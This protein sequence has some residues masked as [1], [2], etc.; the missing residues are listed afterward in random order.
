MKHPMF[1]SFAGDSKQ[2]AHRIKSHFRD[3]LA[4]AY[5]RTG[6]DGDN[7]PAEI[8]ME[9][10]Q[11]QVFVV[12]WSAAYV[13]D[14]PRRP[15]CR[16]ELLTAAKRIQQGNL[17]RFFIVQVDGT[18]LDAKLV[19]P[20]TGDLVDALSTLRSDSRAFMHPASERAIEQRLSLELA[21]I[22]HSDHPILPRDSLERALR[23]VLNTG[24]VHSKTPVIFVNGFHGSGRRTLIREVMSNQRHLT[25][26]PVPLDGIDGPEDLLRIIWGDVFHK[27]RHEQRQMMKH[28]TDDAHAIKGY[29]R[30]IGLQL[31]ANKAYL[32][33][34]K[35]DSTDLNEVAPRWLAECLGVIAP[36]VQPLVFCT[37][38]R[39]LPEFMR[40]LLPNGGDVDVPTLEERESAELAEML[41][42]AVD[43]TKVARWRP[44]MATIVEASANNPKL[45]VD[46]VRAASRRRSLDFLHR[47]IS[48]E[49]Q[50][51]DQRVQQAIEWAWETVKGEPFTVQVLDVIG[52]LGTTHIDSLKEIFV[53]DS[54]RIGDAIYHLVQAGLV[55]HLSESTYR[56]PKA[57]ARKL[58]LYV[59]GALPRSQSM[60]LLRKFARRILSEDEGYSALAMNNRLQLQLSM[61]AVIPE[62]DLVFITAAMLFKAGWQ[63]YRLGQFGAALPMLRRA[64]DRIDRVQDDASRLEIVRYYGLA[65]AK[66]LSGAD[67]AAA[68]RYLDRPGNFSSRF[69]K[70]RAMSLYIQ[71][72]ER[73]ANSQF[74]AAL[75]LYQDAIDQLPE[76]NFNDSLRS[77]MLNEATQCVLRIEPI[78]T[79]LAVSMAERSCAIRGNANSIDM[80]LRALLRR[81]YYD[82]TTPDE[83]IQRNIASM[84][85]W[86]ARLR[87]KC[88]AGGL[89]FYERRVIDRLE[90]EAID[91]VLATGSEFPNLDLSK[92]IDL[93]AR[94]FSRFSEDALL[95]SKWDLQLVD[96]KN[97]DWDALHEEVEQYLAKA[98][99]SKMSRGN[100]ARVHILTYDL[101]TEAGRKRATVELD[102]Y[103]ADGT[104][105]RAVASDIRRQLDAGD[106]RNSRLIGLIGKRQQ[107]FDGEGE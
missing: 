23:N 4:Y 40:R 96:E 8:L 57:L 15:W 107:E 76:G 41:V 28:I 1:L 64:F 53:D 106:K 59:A 74:D 85:E 47:D 2:L 93:C 88:E 29:F 45:M 90:A 19:D 92:V 95:W 49:V 7:F 60:E 30:Q 17:T 63:R 83:E 24:N 39:P 56:I 13:R 65:A 68:V 58:N 50:R 22:E 16:R 34:T 100:A 87:Q 33:I 69:E 3:D 61:D 52:L 12:F 89:S 67:V 62:E 5:T 10:R 104:F 25:G 91:A 55:E 70:V 18:P 84:A 14:D 99:H 27:S 101:A 103:K 44:H 6:G 32:V 79:R 94:A 105:P 77:R 54:I 78:D 20:D 71:A 97:R 66:E 37:I 26:F 21:Q 43:P 82:P 9:L 81:T 11:C 35:E 46:I 73:K 48:H 42:S 36:A 72:F 38:G 102:R 31:V 80:L 86:E 98:G 75:T 51:F